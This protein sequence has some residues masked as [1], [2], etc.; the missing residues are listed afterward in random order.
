MEA[1]AAA[2]GESD[3]STREMNMIWKMLHCRWLLVL[4][5]QIRQC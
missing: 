2:D 3:P 4:D 1:R 5:Q